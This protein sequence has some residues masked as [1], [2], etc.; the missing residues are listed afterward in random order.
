MTVFSQFHVAIATTLI[1]HFSFSC[2]FLSS[3]YQSMAP[4]KRAEIDIG[5]KKQP[6]YHEITQIS[7]GSSISQREVKLPSYP[8][9]L[10]SK[11]N[12]KPINILTCFLRQLIWIVV[13]ENKLEIFL[14]Q[15]SPDHFTIQKFFF[16][17]LHYYLPLL[18]T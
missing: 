15:S 7:S 18:I 12:N 13:P 14:I 8:Y 3:C 17:W 4:G 9:S 16:L 6:W 10:E 11:K 1:Q 2:R 5:K